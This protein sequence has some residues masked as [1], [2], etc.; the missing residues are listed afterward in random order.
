MRLLR[1]ALAILFLSLF[2]AAPAMPQPSGAVQ[3]IAP[4]TRSLGTIRA[5]TAATAATYNSADQTGYNV[6]RI[7][8]TLNQSAHT[9]TPSTTFKLQN[10]DASSGL[11]TD[12]LTSSATTAD[13][14]PNAISAGAGVAT[15]ANVGAGIPIAALWRV[16]VIVA[17]T[18]P[19]VTGTV[20]CSVQ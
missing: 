20:G 16:S 17:G 9:G 2:V 13:A 3:S 4:L 8:C 1:S 12:L 15:T 10:K 5:L 19:V 6:S 11:Y 18:T 14:T 7:I